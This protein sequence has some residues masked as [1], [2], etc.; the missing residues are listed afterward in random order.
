MQVSTLAGCIDSQDKHLGCTY[1]CTY[2]RSCSGLYG[3]VATGLSDGRLCTNISPLN[4]RLIRQGEPVATLLCIHVGK[5]KHYKI[6]Y[7]ITDTHIQTHTHADTHIRTHT[8]RHAHACRHTHMNTHM[9]TDTHM[10]THTCR[11]THADGYT[12]KTFYV[13]LKFKN[14]NIII[15]RC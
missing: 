12:H 4:V 3:M 13:S 6:M 2:L 8:Y 7:I 1:V 15:H 11:H 5:Y 14:T 10:Q 9:Q